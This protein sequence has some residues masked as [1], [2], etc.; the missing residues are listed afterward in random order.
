MP[1]L[2]HARISPQTQPRNAVSLRCEV[3]AGSRS[4]SNWS[5]NQGC[6][7]HDAR[8]QWRRTA[9]EEA[10]MKMPTTLTYPRRRCDGAQGASTAP[11]GNW[12]QSTTSVRPLEELISTDRLHRSP[13]KDR[14]PRSDRSAHTRCTARLRRRRFEPFV[15]K[16]QVIWSG[17]APSAYHLSYIQHG[18]FPVART[19]SLQQSMPWTPMALIYSRQ[20]TQCLARGRAQRPLRERSEERESRAFRTKLNIRLQQG[21]LTVWPG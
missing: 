17:L 16:H 15:A 7:I 3:P 21:R 2:P 18:S 9:S 8:R 19:P 6:R 13:A 10:P 4:T 5:S 1:L 11:L 20:A 12:C 14:S